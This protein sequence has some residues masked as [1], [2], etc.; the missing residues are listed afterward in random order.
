VLY[1]GLGHAYYVG[2]NGA[3]AGYGTLGPKGWR[4]VEKHAAGPTIQKALSV[5]ENEKVATFVELP[6][7][8]RTNTGAEP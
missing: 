5:V 7:D 4:W 1:L 2:G 3:V 8:V 6:L